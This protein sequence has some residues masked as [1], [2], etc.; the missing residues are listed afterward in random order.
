[1][2]VKIVTANCCKI[3]LKV[4]V[5]DIDGNEKTIQV[6]DVK[7]LSAEVRKKSSVRVETLGHSVHF[8]ER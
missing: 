3:K 5:W 1:M 4:K 2:K 7:E 6:E 8:E